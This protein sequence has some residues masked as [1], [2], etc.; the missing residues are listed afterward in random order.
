MTND[1]IT[2]LKL[3][4]RKERYFLIAQA[5]GNNNFTLSE[6]FR[7]LIST[8]LDLFIPPDAFAAMDYHLD[9]IYASLFASTK[10]NLNFIELN[11]LKLNKNQEDIDFLIAFKEGTQYHLILIEAKAETGWTNK[12]IDSKA[13][14]F[15]EIF[16]TDKCSW[17]NV[18]PHLLITSPR[19][20]R[21]LKLD[22]LPLYLYRPMNYIWFPLNIPDNLIKITRCNDLGKPSINGL[23]WNIEKT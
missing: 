13:K 10:D 17:E 14:K 11:E 7:K 23:K 20:P 3:F 15:K 21:D 6:S 2:L 18:T 8:K 1:L 22:C 9:W 5:L 12:Q 19:M 16:G 4:N